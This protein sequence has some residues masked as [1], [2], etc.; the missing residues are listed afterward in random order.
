M[1]L[2]KRY[3]SF[4]PKIL[5]SLLRNGYSR[6]DY[7]RKHPVLNRIGENVYFYSRI[8]PADAKLLRLG[9]NVVIATNVRFLGHDRVDIML[10]GMMQERYYKFYDCIDVGN[11]VFIGSDCTILP[12]VKI[13]DN[14][15]IG[16]GAIV[17]KDLPSGGIWD[18]IP[19]KQIGNFDDFIA[20]RM[21]LI[22]PESD[23]DEL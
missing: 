23:P 5:F 20:K 11:N 10:S 22:K 21:K 3:C 18:G 14:S 2:I 12:G 19:A 8:Y 9:N 16:A 13:G 15:I 17:T 6:A 4:V 1:S 7:L